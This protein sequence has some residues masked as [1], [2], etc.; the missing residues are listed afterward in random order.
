MARLF[1]LVVDDE[2]FDV[3]HERGGNHFSWVS[4]PSP[5]YGF[6]VGRS[7]GAALTEEQARSA[8]RGF[9]AEIDPATGYLRD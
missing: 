8:I 7:D 9:L 1:C 5:G 2:V 6:T 3:A 4:G